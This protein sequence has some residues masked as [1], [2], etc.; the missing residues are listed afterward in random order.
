MAVLKLEVLDRVGISAVPV[1]DVD[2]VERAGISVVAEVVVPSSLAVV[3]GL[4]AAVVAAVESPFVV[5]SS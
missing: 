3:E 1:S 4:V 2:E 5:V